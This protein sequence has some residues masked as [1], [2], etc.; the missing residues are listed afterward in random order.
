MLPAEIAPGSDSADLFVPFVRRADPDRGSFQYAVIG[1]MKPGVTFAA[2]QADLHTVS[3]TLEQ[4]YPATNTH[5]SAVLERSRVW[6]ASDDLR[7]TLWI[8]LGAVGV[9]LVIAC[10]NVTNLLLA[11]ASTLD[12]PA[13]APSARHLA[14]AAETSFASG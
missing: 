9:L 8:L 13:T 4:Q 12:A 1:R 7:R 14:P 6:V 10:V 5:L 11:R 2:A 3:K